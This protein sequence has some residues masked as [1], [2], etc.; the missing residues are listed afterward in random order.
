MSMSTKEERVKMLAD[1][2]ELLRQNPS[3]SDLDQERDLRELRAEWEG[4]FRSLAHE[5]ISYVIKKKVAQKGYRALRDMYF[6]AAHDKFYR[7]PRPKEP[8]WKP[9][10]LL[11]PA[12]FIAKMQR[13]LDKRKIP[14]N[15]E[16]LLDIS[17]TAE[18]LEEWKPSSALEGL[19]E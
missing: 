14:L 12:D 16:G 1:T 8:G 18:K 15:A 7:T 17:I 19:T 13:E 3:Y 10:H 6:H 9:Y 2:H 5:D 4:T 11:T